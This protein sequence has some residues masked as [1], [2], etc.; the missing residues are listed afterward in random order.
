[1]SS[2]H[3]WPELEAFVLEAEPLAADGGADAFRRCAA[4]LARLARARFAGAWVDVALER[5]MDRGRH[6][7]DPDASGAVL[8]R[9]A[10]FALSLAVIESTPEVRADRLEGLAHHLGLAVLGPGALE[11]ERYRL[12]PPH[13]FEVLDRARIL[14]G[15]L[16]ERLDPGEARVF[17]AGEDVIRT[18]ARGAGTAALVLRSGLIHR[19]RWV[20]DP[21]TRA[22]SLPVAADPQSSRV[23]FACRTLARL[24]TQSDVPALERVAAHPDHFVRWTALQGIV[25]LD[26]ERGRALMERALGDPHPHIRSAAARFLRD[27]A[28]ALAEPAG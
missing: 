27:S 14:E 12:P 9:T 23:E 4:P 10:H 15:P 24:G 25:E 11:I 3:R 19:I 26:F 1:M 20:Y 2:T 22:P 8:V 5:A 28:P 16:S 7:A 18:T 13:C 21:A 6:G 17:A